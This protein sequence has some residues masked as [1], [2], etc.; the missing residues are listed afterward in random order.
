MF[1]FETIFT[2]TGPEA[3]YEMSGLVR[4][5]FVPAIGMELTLFPKGPT[6][7]V[8]HVRMNVTSASGTI[9]LS[10][11]DCRNF[12]QARFTQEEEGLGNARWNQLF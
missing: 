10:L 1:E 9:L 4:L 6:L 12:S 7:T 8:E 5:E 3:Q 2:I 11:H